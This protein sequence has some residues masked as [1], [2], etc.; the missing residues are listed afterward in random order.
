MAGEEQRDV[1]PGCRPPLGEVLR[2]KNTHLGEAGGNTFAN[3][4]NDTGRCFYLG[5]AS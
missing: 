1:Q 4:L 2:G 3:T 5:L